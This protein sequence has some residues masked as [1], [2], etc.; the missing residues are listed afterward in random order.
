VDCSVSRLAKARY[1]D[2]MEF[3]RDVQRFQL[4]AGF[5]QGSGSLSRSGKGVTFHAYEGVVA[6]QQNCL[7]RV[8][9][10]RSSILR[11]QGGFAFTLHFHGSFVP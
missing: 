3:S 7:F 6:L 10:E 4:V 8:H 2:T 1:A 11:R 9:I 5:E